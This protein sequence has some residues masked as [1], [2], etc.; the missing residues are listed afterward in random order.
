MAA[1]PQQWCSDL[2]Y[3]KFMMAALRKMAKIEV[4]H[5]NMNIGR[6]PKNNEIEILCNVQYW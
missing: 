4:K 1:L 6:I 3:L 2:A 5:C